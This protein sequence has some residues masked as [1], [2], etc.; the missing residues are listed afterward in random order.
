MEEP[1]PRFDGRVAIVT[2]GALGIGGAV[3]R[4]LAREGAK[5]LIA[6]YDEPAGRANARRI[7]DA[8]GQAVVSKVDVSNGADIKRMIEE[9]LVRWNRVDILVQNAFSVVNMEAKIYGDAVSVP[10]DMW[11]AGMAVLAKAIYLGAK[12][13]VPVMRR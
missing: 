10:E 5:V 8:G 13:V 6:D 11:D 9:T 3:A 12:S 7:A 2:G 4:R 1:M